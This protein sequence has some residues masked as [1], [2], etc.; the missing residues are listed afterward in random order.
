MKLAVYSKFLRDI[1]NVT[2]VSV[3]LVVMLPVVI[4]SQPK[5]DE[6]R[7]CATTDILNAYEA[8]LHSWCNSTEKKA[9]S[10]L[11]PHL[12]NKEYMNV[13]ADHVTEKRNGFWS[14]EAPKTV[15]KLLDY[16]S[17]HKSLQT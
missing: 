11:V 7:K 12:D 8:V 6:T 16:L 14:S 2:Y 3:F 10:I 17:L 1:R 5:R 13:M 15:G 4:M 9:S